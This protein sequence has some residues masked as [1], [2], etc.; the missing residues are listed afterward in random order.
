MS[1]GPPSRWS[2]TLAAARALFRDAG[3]RTGCAGHRARS[4]RE[5]DRPG[6]PE[7]GNEPRRIWAGVGT[8]ASAPGGLRRSRVYVADLSPPAGSGCGSARMP[9]RAARR[10][11]RIS[12]PGGFLV[13]RRVLHDPLAELAGDPVQFAVKP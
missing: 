5:N 7:T 1:T 2:W 11:R 8:R 10:A 4:I 12:A 13:F 6:P 9:T 3:S